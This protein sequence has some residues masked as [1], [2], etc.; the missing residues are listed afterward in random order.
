M[1]FKIK[2]NNQSADSNG[3]G[4]G[5]AV[6]KGLIEKM[7]GKIWFENNSSNGAT[8]YFSIPYL[9]SKTDIGKIKKRVTIYAG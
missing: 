9:K 6:C 7:D 1:H 3:L 2:K 8:F 4:I 5:L